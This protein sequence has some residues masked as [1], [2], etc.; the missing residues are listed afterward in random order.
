MIALI[1]LWKTWELRNKEVHGSV[2]G[3][4]SNLVRWAKEFLTT[5][6]EAQTK[7]V[8]SSS[9][10]LPQ[11]WIPQIRATSR[12]MSMLHSQRTRIIFELV[13]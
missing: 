2:E 3:F 10:H 13:W 4:P 9:M 11:V 7:P 5:Y 6:Q 12:L 8:S 1:M